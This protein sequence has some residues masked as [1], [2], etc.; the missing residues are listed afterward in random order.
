MLSGQLTEQRRRPA[1]LALSGAVDP[2]SLRYALFLAPAAALGFLLA[3]PLGKHL[4]ARRTR[5]TAMALALTGA[6][7]LLVRQFG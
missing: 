4:D 3:R 1:A 7:V 5:I 2:H 6:T